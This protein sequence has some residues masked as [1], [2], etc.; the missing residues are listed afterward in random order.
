MMSL[1]IALPEQ[2]YTYITDDTRSCDADTAFVRTNQNRDFCKNANECGCHSI[3]DVEKISTLLGSNKIKIIG[4]TGT[5]GK[6]TTAAA[7]Y[8]ILL[9][10]GHKCALLGT[11]GFFVNEER[12]D[13]KSL[14][15]PPILKTLAYIYQAVEAGCEYFVMEV[16]SHAI[17]QKRIE[18]LKFALKI[19]TNI[20]SDH[21][22]YHKTLEEYIAVKNS[23]FADEGMKLINR[24]DK[25]VDF[26]YK[27]A[28]TYSIE[29]GGSFSTKAYSLKSGISFV[30]QH[31]QDTFDV[32]SPLH[33]FFN[34]YNLLAA[35]SS[36]KL[37]TK[38]PLEKIV[39]VVDNFAGVAGRMEVVSEEP[40]VIVDFAHTDDG[41]EKV[42]SSLSAKD[43]IVVFGAGGDRDKVKRPKMGAVAASY[44]KTIIVT[45][46]NPRSE[47]P[48]VIAD[49]IVRGISNRD[50]LIVNLNRKE[51]IETALKMQKPHEV[52]M[53]LGKGDETTQI[54][55]DK[56]FPFD[57]R[58]VVREA[59]NIK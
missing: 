40:L 10:L 4:I 53:I 9:D 15:T 56:T 54:V 51:A 19:H 3:V 27:N 48:K 47:D 45:S 14:T 16:S 38:E 6:T 5:N 22:D 57:D 52:V 21:L 43:I 1:K 31:F 24:D 41:M 23:F 32:H 55:Y 46:D 35:V 39:E 8:S 59:L 18:T 26:N 37:L 25:Y 13:A 50:N 49:D 2:E 36:V 7:I 34:I 44:A 12:V 58:E 20:T 33:G 28:Y 29:S 30:M 42:L 17:V 11:R